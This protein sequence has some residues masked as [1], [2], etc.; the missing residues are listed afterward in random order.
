MHLK[1]QVPNALAMCSQRNQKHL[2]QLKRQI[3][4]MEQKRVA[5]R[6]H[7][8]EEGMHTRVLEAQRQQELLQHK[9][10]KLEQ[11]R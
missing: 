1:Q 8:F 7:V 2:V 5:D 6:R 3:C 4:A 10:N 11:L 9:K